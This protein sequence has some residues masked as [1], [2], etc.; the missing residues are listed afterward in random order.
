MTKVTTCLTERR[1]Q[2]GSAASPAEPI[3]QDLN[4]SSC[5]AIPTSAWEKLRVARWAKLQRANF[6]S[7]FDAESKGE[8]NLFFC[9]AIPAAAWKKLKVA[10]WPKLEKANFAGCFNSDSE[11][12]EELNLSSC[13]MIPAAAW[14]KLDIASWPILH[15]ANFEGCFNL[16]SV[17]AEGAA[18]LLRVLTKCAEL[19]DTSASFSRFLL[20]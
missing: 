20:T 11:A 18:T 1:I 15:K 14:K 13:F 12:A 16:D 8:L 7:C 5:S 4:L 10:R 3:W 17:G 2:R 19:V 6:E 9:S